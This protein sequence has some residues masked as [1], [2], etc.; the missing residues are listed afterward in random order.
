MD[1]FTARVRPPP[2]PPVR[3]MLQLSAMPSSGHGRFSVLTYN[4]LADLYAKV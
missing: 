3:A 1:I 2:N 4:L